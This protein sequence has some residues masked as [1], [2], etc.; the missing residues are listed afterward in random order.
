MQDVARKPPATKQ[1][2]VASLTNC[3]RKPAIRQAPGPRPEN[4]Q[5]QAPCGFQRCSG[6]L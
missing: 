4:P 6:A 3:L 2:W 1:F 5:T